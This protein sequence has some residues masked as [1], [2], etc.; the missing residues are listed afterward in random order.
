MRLARDF[1]AGAAM[2]VLAGCATVDPAVRYLPESPYYIN[3]RGYARQAKKGS[4]LTIGAD[5][6]PSGW[7]IVLAIAVKNTGKEPLTIYPERIQGYVSSTYEPNPTPIQVRSARESVAEMLTN[8]NSEAVA[9]ALMGVLSAAQESN[10]VARQMILNRTG[11]SMEGISRGT[12]QS[13]RRSGFLG[14]ETLE[15]NETAVG[16]VSLRGI[17]A[18]T[19]LDIGWTVGTEQYNVSFRP[20]NKIV[21]I[22]LMAPPAPEKSSRQQPPA[23]WQ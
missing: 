14:R 4:E 6:D 7:G 10:P 3:D 21:D 16:T 5:K 22:P 18:F 23:P 19:R 11:E 17:Y 12:A 9:V 15:P 1:V 13:I 20:E 8:A 2:L